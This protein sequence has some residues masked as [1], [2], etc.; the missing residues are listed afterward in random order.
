MLIYNSVRNQLRKSI[1]STPSGGEKVNFD[2]A[3]PASRVIF[4]RE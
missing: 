3:R 4:L 2:E 1:T